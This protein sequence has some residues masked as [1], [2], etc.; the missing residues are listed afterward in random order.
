MKAISRWLPLLALGMSLFAAPSWAAEA[1][2]ASAA[3]AAVERGQ[4]LLEKEDYPAAIQAFSE[5]QRLDSKGV[6]AYI[7]RGTS[8]LFLSRFDL[9]LADFDEAMRL[10][11]NNSEA[12]RGRGAIYRRKKDFGKA[13]AE[14]EEAIRYDPRNSA[15]YRARGTVHSDKGESDKAIADYNMA[16][17]LNP[18][19]A[20]A[21]YDRAIEE[22]KKGQ[23]EKASADLEEALRLKPQCAY[24]YRERGSLY[25]KKGDSRKAEA[26]FAQARQLRLKAV[27]EERGLAK[28]AASRE[29]IDSVEQHIVKE[30]K[31][32]EY[33]D[34]V[35]QELLAMVRDWHLADLERKLA[36]AKDQQRQG[37]LS[38]DGLSKTE[39]EIAE[40]L[41]QE[42]AAILRA[43]DNVH[44]LDEVIRGKCACCMGDALMCNILGRSIGLDVQGLDVPIMASGQTVDDRGHLACLIHLADE[45]AAIVDVTGNLGCAALVSAPFRFT[46][47][48]CE[49]GCYW[50]L[51]DHRNPLGLHPLVLPLNYS[52]LVSVLL[53]SRSIECREKG[54][55]KRA[56]AM[57][58]E[59]M[60]RGP[61]DAW[62]YELQGRI[63]EDSGEYDRAIADFDAAIQHNPSYATAYLARGRVYLAKGHID[64]GIADLDEAIRLNPKFAVAYATRGWVRARR[65]ESNRFNFP[66]IAEAKGAS[67]SRDGTSVRWVT[68][69]TISNN[70]EHILQENKEPSQPASTD[71]QTFRGQEE[72]DNIVI[73]HGRERALADYSEAIRLAPKD[74][75]YYKARGLVHAANG[76]F[77]K[78][79]VDLTEAIRLDPKDADGLTRRS[80]VYAEK[81]DLDKAIADMTEVIRLNPKSP[82]AYERR[83]NLYSRK[84]DTEKAKAD[85]AQAARLRPDED[86]YR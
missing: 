7:G 27:L 66:N 42:V 26:D 12:H 81:G 23:I 29:T 50:E 64:R 58:A 13:F 21:F 54:D 37:K 17:R 16:M 72:L 82:E 74:S 68:D 19:D 61:T 60:R 41:C 44:E 38:K 73:R 2:P 39:L 78:S 22:S 34:A 20:W 59:S 3:K 62:A 85:F 49:K 40:T 9:A 76:E 77:E 53:A 18:N 6:P 55:P 33:S 70:V 47:N 5:A 35:A 56:R 25:E 79:L 63:H 51:K 83:A 14:C 48:Y 57:A 46:E 1:A 86:R 15:A 8:Y 84:H 28:A 32:L 69:I 71:V 65:A 75:S 45:Q 24:A 36:A 80:Q 31:R 30:V 67:S 43:S 4:A 52:D 10:E 11:P